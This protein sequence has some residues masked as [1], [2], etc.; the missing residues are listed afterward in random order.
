MTRFFTLLLTLLLLGPLSAQRGLLMADAGAKTERLV[1]AQAYPTYD[2]YLQIMKGL[3][4]KYP[5]RCALETWGTLP[6][7][8]KILTLR[9]TSRVTLPNARPRVLCS[10]AMHGDETAGYWLLLQMAEEVLRENP[11]NVLGD[12]ELFINP[13]ANPDGAFA[14]GN[15]TL[16]GSRR[17]NANGVD[18]NRNYPDPDDG[19]HPDGNDYQPET[20]IFMRAARE[21]GFDL[22]IN[23]H[24]GAEVFNY[25]WDTYRNRHADNAWWLRVSRDFAR[26]AQTASGRDT[27]FQDRHSGVTNGHDWYPIAGSRQDYMNYYHRCREATLEVSNAKRFPAQQLPELWRYVAPA[28]LGYV[29]EA[30][31]GL[32]GTVTDY[33]TGQPVVAKISIPGHDRENSDV[34]T[35]AKLGDFHRYLAAGAY[36]VEISAQG[37]ESQWIPV[38]IYD[39]RRT[40]LNIQLERSYAAGLDARRKR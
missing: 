39:G 2:H 3:A 1:P 15:H 13:L 38:M 28:L 34:F 23:L 9:L 17:G 14:A 36:Q 35:E 10:A 6:S 32:H 27:Y 29:N 16:D 24:G 4:K 12:V 8:R 11:G 20:I 18:L 21:K 30:R 19:N 5:D 7:G 31:Y 26:R 33:H 22:A 37:Y 25:P 40:D